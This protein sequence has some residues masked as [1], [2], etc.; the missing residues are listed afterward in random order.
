LIGRRKLAS[1]AFAA[2]VAAGSCALTSKSKPLEIR[3]FTPETPR[4]P[5]PGA[6]PVATQTLDVDLR[7]GRIRAASYLRDKIVYRDATREL[8][9]YERLRWTEEPDAYVERMLTRALFEQR[10]IRQR[11]TG[12]G[13]TLDVD[14]AAFEEWRAPRRAA[15]VELIWRLR[16]EKLVWVQRTV[17]AERPIEA[18]RSGSGT[19]IAQAMAAALADALERIVADVVAAMAAG[20][21]GGHQSE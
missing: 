4:D 5:D 21:P 15:R 1:I 6:K 19:A 20:A 16:D 17:T 10:G 13:L 3:Y 9:F 12:S 14:I 18:D 2:L 8:G 11:V 7:L